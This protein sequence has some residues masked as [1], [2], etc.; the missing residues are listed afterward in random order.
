MGVNRQFQAQRAKYKNR[1]ISQ[2]INTINV[3]LHLQEDVR[4]IKHKSWVVR[5]AV[6][7]YPRWRTAAILKIENTQ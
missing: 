6:M 2:N 7:P 3:Q 5:Y 1:D 4:A